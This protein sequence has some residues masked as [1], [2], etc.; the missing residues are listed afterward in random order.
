MA[1]SGY[2]EPVGTRTA[3]SEREDIDTTVNEQLIV[4][5]YSANH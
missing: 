5:F 3:A 4:E 1:R 2:E